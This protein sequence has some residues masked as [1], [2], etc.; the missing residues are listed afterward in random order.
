MRRAGKVI[1]FS[2]GHVHPSGARACSSVL[3]GDIREGAGR[4]QE[5]AD[6][7]LAYA[8]VALVGSGVMTDDELRVALES[9]LGDCWERLEDVV[10]ELHGVHEVSLAAIVERIGTAV[11]HDAS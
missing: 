3:S 6:G 5:Y 1:G 8:A 10:S 11:A 7:R 9:R 4:A 2:K